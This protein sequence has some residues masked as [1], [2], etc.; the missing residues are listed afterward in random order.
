MVH[1]TLGP[2]PSTLTKSP[3]SLP[4]TKPSIRISSNLGSSSGI[5]TRAVPASTSSFARALPC[6]H[7]GGGGDNTTTQTKASQ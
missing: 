3:L 6:R 7:G 4:L 5:K 2:G 1:T